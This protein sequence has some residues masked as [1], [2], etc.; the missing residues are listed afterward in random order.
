MTEQQRNEA[1]PCC[2]CH[3]G[4]SADRPAQQRGLS[5]Y[6]SQRELRETWANIA[7]IPLAKT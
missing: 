6:M 1:E 5:L 2:S 4:P 3:R 7:A